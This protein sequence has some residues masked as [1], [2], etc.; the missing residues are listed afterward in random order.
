MACPSRVTSARAERGTALLLAL[1]TVSVRTELEIDDLCRQ[2]LPQLR[3]GAVY[4]AAGARSLG[5][6][7]RKQVAEWEVDGALPRASLREGFAAGAAAGGG[8]AAGAV[9]APVAM[10]SQQFSTSSKDPG[11]R[12]RIS[13]SGIPHFDNRPFEAINGIIDLE[14]QMFRLLGVTDVNI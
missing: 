4:F 9:A 11:Q 13:R 2:Q 10:A 3:L 14:M 5:V 1:G 8:A 6:A 12:N 7:P